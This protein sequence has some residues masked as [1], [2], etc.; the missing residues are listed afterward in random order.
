MQLRSHVSLIFGGTSQD[1]AP[2]KA[3][4]LGFWATGVGRQASDRPAGRPDPR[5]CKSS[6]MCCTLIRYLTT[7][8]SV[9]YGLLNLAKSLFI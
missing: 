8:V 6:V 5:L 2:L 4:K 3:K 7:D 1:L 9:V